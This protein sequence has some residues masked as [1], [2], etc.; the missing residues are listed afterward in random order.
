[1]EE[2]DLRTDDFKDLEMRAL[3]GDVNLII[4][5]AYGH[6]YGLGCKIDVEKAKLLC[7]EARE[8]GS[9]LA[10]AMCFLYGYPTLDYNKA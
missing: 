6:K 7:I 10:N 8:K 4:E 2:K 9:K 5:V 3:S 1:M